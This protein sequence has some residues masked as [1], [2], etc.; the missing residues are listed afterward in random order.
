MGIVVL[1]AGYYSL[2]QQRVAAPEGIVANDDGMYLGAQE[3]MKVNAS[4][5]ELVA[6]SGSWRC[7]VDSTTAQTVSAGV[8]YVSGGK[9]RADFTT[10]VPNYGSVETHMIADGRDVYTWSSLMSQGMRTPM[11]TPQ[12]TQG[13]A[14]SGQGVSANTKYAYTC[15]PWNADAALFTVPTNITF[16]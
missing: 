12:A 6:R 3:P 11:V 2:Q 9:V 8:T 16:R 10:T 7:A 15:E 5:A 1:G 14:P 4:L 13:A